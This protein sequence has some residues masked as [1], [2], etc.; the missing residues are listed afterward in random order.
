MML[1]KN[2][3]DKYYFNLK[4]L[5]DSHAGILESSEKWTVYICMANFCETMIESDRRGKTFPGELHNLYKTIIEKK[6]YKVED[7]YPYLH[8]RLYL[9]ILQNGLQQKEFEWSENFINVYKNELSEDYREGT[10]NLCCALFYFSKKEFEKSLKYLNRVRYDDALYFLQV[11]ALTLQIYY[12]LNLFDSGISAIDSYKHYLK[13]K[14][15]IPERYKILHKNFVNIMNRLIKIKSGED[16][17]ESSK[18]D[19]AGEDFK[20][21]L[22]ND[23]IMEKIEEVKPVNKFQYS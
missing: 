11:K 7:W 3:E 17:Y 23:W 15:E 13:E 5:L 8:H 18:F 4:D 21:I 10:Y 16:E 22:K 14:K 2:D 1:L 6:I 20:N 9:N 19:F 12:E